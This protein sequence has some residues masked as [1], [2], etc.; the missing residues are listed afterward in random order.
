M[1]TPV[2]CRYLFLYLLVDVWSRRIVGWRVHARESAALAAEMIQ[3]IS[4]ESGIDPNSLVLH[5]DN[6]KPMSGSTMLATSLRR[7]LR[8]L[9][10]RRAPPQGIR[11]V[12][13]DKRHYRREMT[14]ATFRALSGLLPVSE[15][16]MTKPFSLPY[17]NKMVERMFCPA[18]QSSREATT[19]LLLG[20]DDMFD[21]F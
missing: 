21:D 5:S 10:Q 19:I 17:K 12:T 11:F 2:R 15:W 16:S 18:H 14:V 7:L 9:V 13:P 1:A 6:G 3:G 4:E 8:R 20:F